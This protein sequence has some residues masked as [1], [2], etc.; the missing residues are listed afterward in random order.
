VIIEVNPWC[1]H[2]A[3]VPVA[4]IGRSPTAPIARGIYV[5]RVNDIRIEAA[6]AHR[7]GLYGVCSAISDWEKAML[8]AFGN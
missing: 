7:D 2:S 6:S 8:Q 4:S 1:A 3:A 5:V